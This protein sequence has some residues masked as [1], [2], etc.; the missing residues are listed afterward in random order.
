MKN[1]PSVSERAT[2]KHIEALSSSRT[3]TCRN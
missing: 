3:S 2:Y 1:A